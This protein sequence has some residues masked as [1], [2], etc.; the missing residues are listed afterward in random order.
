MNHTKWECKYH[1][2]FIPKYRHKALYGTLRRHL[3]GVFRQL[4]RH[5]ECEIEE[6]HLM[7]DHVHM[8]VS[9]PPKYP[10]SQVMRYIRGNSAIH[11]ARTYGGKRRNFVGRHFC[12][13]GYWVSRVGR[14][15]AA[16]RSHIQAQE[17]EDQ[18]L[19]QPGLFG[20]DGRLERLQDQSALS[21]SQFQASGF[22]GG[23]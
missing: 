17:K 20:S 8:L 18:R 14:N 7:P 16:V 12:A 1:V 5:K 15:E 6:G 13:R 10:V 19:E 11:I 3:G 4:A 2:I 9:I 22:A 23:R 21:G